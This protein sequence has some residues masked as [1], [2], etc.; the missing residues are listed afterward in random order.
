M[1]LQIS[2]AQGYNEIGSN[3][4]PQTHQRDFKA[5][6]CFRIANE[7]IRGPERER[8]K[9]AARR[10]PIASEPVPAQILDRGQRSRRKDF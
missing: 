10:N 8:I 1:R 4:R 7:K 9:G 2:A 3:T 5:C 6:F